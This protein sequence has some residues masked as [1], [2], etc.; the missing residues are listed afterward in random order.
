[1]LCLVYPIEGRE[2]GCRCVLEGVEVIGGAL[3]ALM[4]C[5]RYVFTYESGF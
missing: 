4:V 1:M 2:D 3:C 5:S